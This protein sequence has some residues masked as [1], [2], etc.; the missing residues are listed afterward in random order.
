MLRKVSLFPFAVL[1]ALWEAPLCGRAMFRIG[2]D[3]LADAS[4]G[5]PG[6]DRGPRLTG[7][8]WSRSV[9]TVFEVRT[10]SLLLWAVERKIRLWRALISRI[11]FIRAG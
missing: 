8:H 2:N 3:P 9:V 7:F 10:T 1:L 6:G 5:V 11:T 4:A